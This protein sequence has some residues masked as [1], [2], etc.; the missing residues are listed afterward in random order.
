MKKKTLRK[1]SVWRFLLNI[2]NG[3]SQK[4]KLMKLENKKEQL[5]TRKQRKKYKEFAPFLFI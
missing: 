2:F 1:Q 4:N 3:F 5:V